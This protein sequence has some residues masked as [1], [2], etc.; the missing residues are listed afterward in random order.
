[1]SRQPASPDARTVGSNEKTND[2]GSSPGR[3]ENPEENSG[4]GRGR[5]ALVAGVGHARAASD[6]GDA[7]G[8]RASA[9]G[10]ADGAWAMFGVGGT[11]AVGKAGKCTAVTRREST[12]TGLRAS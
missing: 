8:R 7:G 9:S 10:G 5:P 3:G 6:G 4:E 11:Q 1:M 2:K 12:A